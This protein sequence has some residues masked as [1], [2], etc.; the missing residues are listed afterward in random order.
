MSDSSERP[1]EDL[2]TRLSEALAGSNPEH[3]TDR[4][5]PVIESF[6]A[7]FE[8]VPKRQFETHLATLTRL[9]EHIARLEA[10]VAELEQQS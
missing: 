10:R 1:L 8:L 6:F 3:L 2:F 5:R 7:Q 9:E 4:M